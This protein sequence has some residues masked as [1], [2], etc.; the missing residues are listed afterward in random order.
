MSFALKN[1]IIPSIGFSLLSLKIFFV[2]TAYLIKK[3]KYV[4]NFSFHNGKK[5]AYHFESSH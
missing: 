3:H 1:R 2:D 5:R 4:W